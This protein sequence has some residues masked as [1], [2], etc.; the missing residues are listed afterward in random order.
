M[1]VYFNFKKEQANDPVKVEK[2]SLSI[3]LPLHNRNQVEL[4]KEDRLK[5]PHEP[6]LASSKKQNR[7][8]GLLIVSIAI[9]F[10]AFCY[11]VWKDERTTD[12]NTPFKDATVM[13]EFILNQ[14]VQAR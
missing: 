6:S 5:L 7:I 3:L 2:G 13:K 14:V 10:L 11:T 12:P 4:K 9:A 8:S 1:I